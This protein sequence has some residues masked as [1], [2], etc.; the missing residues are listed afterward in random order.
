MH[1]L[2]CRIF[3]CNCRFLYLQNEHSYE[4][5]ETKLICCIEK[6]GCLLAQDVVLEPIQRLVKHF[7]SEFG[8]LSKLEYFVSK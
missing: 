8:I 2:Q 6:Q 4:L 3:R 7:V 1:S 5:R